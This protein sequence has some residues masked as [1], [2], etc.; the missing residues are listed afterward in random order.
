MPSPH[1][2]PGAGVSVAVGVGNCGVCVGVAVL[3][4]ANLFEILNSLDAPWQTLGW[5]EL[6][7]AKWSAAAALHSP[8][9]ALYAVLGS[10]VTGVALGFGSK[11][12]HEALDGVLE[13]RGIAK[14]LKESYRGG[15]K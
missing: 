10:A 11:F 15:G 14:R 4:K 9:T 2:P 8:S 6:G 7:D 1:D 5:M 12:W 3:V 13:L